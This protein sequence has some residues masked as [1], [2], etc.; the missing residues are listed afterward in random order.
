[1]KMIG[2][3]NAKLHEPDAEFPHKPGVNEYWQE[4]VVLHWFDAKA[5]IGGYFRIGHEPHLGNA[6]LWCSYYCTDGTVFNHNAKFPLRDEDRIPN[7]FAVGDCCKYE[8]V[9]GKIVWTSIEPEIQARLVAE[10][11]HQPIDLYPSDSGTL[12]DDYCKDHL[13]VAS[14][15]TGEVVFEGKRYEIDGLG[16]RDHSWGE[17]RWHTLL[18]HRW[19]TG[20]LSTDCSFGAM[21][22]HAQDNT[23]NIWRA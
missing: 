23:L 5:G 1:M 6:V 4:S 13:E 19:V 8:V 11:F 2:N 12:S 7:G 21:S 15:V 9:D 18:T 16:Y 3:G 17:R 20:V 10:D 22:W 14:R